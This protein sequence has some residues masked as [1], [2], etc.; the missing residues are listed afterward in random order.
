[1]VVTVI[2]GLIFATVSTMVVLPVFY[3]ILFRI[4]S[5]RDP[6]PVPQ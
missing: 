3:A 5:P 2:F 1:M 4:P 6:A